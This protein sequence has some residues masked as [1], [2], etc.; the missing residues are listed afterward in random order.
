[1]GITTR[2]DFESYK[3]DKQIGGSFEEYKHKLARDLYTELKTYRVDYLFY[4][5]REKASFLVDPAK[6]Y[7]FLKEVYNDTVV[8]IYQIL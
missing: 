7:P 5:P 8:K 4:G 6:T 3:L 1:M 2:Q